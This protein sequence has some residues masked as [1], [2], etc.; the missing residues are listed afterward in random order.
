MLLLQ[1][2]K[3]SLPAFP[4]NFMYLSSFL[5]LGDTMNGLA[6]LSTNNTHCKKDC[7]QE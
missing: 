6:F 1:Y 5:L 2:N 3:G 4:H 7:H